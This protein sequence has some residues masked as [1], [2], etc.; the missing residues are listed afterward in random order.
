MAGQERTDGGVGG[1]AIS[2][3][4]RR[5]AIREAEFADRDL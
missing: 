5:S 3:I 1:E 2:S 4:P